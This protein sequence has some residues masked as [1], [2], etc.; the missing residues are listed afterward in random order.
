MNEALGLVPNLSAGYPAQSSEFCQSPLHMN[1]APLK[2]PALLFCN[3]G[4]TRES[5]GYQSDNPLLERLWQKGKHLLPGGF[6]FSALFES[7]DGHIGGGVRHGSEQD[8]KASI[9]GMM[10]CCLKPQC[11]GH[12]NERALGR[13]SRKRME[14]LPV[15]NAGVE[16]ATKRLSRNLAHLRDASQGG[17]VSQDGA[18]QT[19]ALTLPGSASPLRPNR[20]G[21]TTP[22]AA[23]PPIRM[24]QEA[25]PAT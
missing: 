23:L 17:A 25:C 8:T 9:V 11:I 5:I 12:G 6:A 16:S 10:I 14:A 21:G 24:G 7:E 2:V 3:T 18:R 15:V 19:N 22:T 13:Q 20:A 4:K 1:V